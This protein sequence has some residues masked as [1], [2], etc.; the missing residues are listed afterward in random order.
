MADRDKIPRSIHYRQTYKEICEGQDKATVA[1]SAI[2]RIAKS[3]HRNGR[4]GMMLLKK[5]ESYLKPLV[6]N[7]L[8]RQLDNLDWDREHEWI[9]NQTD[10]IDGNNC[11]I[12][13]ARRACHD[14]LFLLENGQTVS[15]H[16][17]WESFRES[18]PEYDVHHNDVSYDE[19][20]ERIQGLEPFLG[21]EIERYLDGERPSKVNLFEGDLTV[22][23]IV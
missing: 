8:L 22:G 15:D 18:I 14:I 3:I 9:D 10:Y 13:C 17:E 12:E 21:L 4:G 19:L 20:I 6:E 7:S 23:Q 5:A 1:Q 2:Q 11:H 16:Y